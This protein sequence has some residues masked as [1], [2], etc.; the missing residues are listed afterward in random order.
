MVQTEPPELEH[1][2]PPLLHLH[3]LEEV[4]VMH[5][6]EAEQHKPAVVA[7]PHRLEPEQVLPEQ[8]LPEQVLPE[9]VQ[10]LEQVQGPEPVQLALEKEPQ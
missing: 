5:S 10:A 8:V 3:S 9:Q 2:K 4:V 7:E 1:H 6:L